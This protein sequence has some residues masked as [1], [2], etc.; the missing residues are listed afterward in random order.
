MRLRLLPLAAVAAAAIACAAA[1]SSGAAS[2]SLTLVH[3]GQITVATYGNG[4][5]TIVVN[6]NGTLGGTS[7]AWINAFAKANGLK[8]KLFQTTFTSAILAVQQGKADLTLDI[9]YNPARGKTMLYTYPFSVEGLEVFTNKSFDYTG[10][11]SLQGKKVAAVTGVVWDSALQKTFGSGLQLYPSQPEAATALLN[12]QVDAYFEADAQYFAPPISKSPNIV[13][14]N[15]SPGQFGVPGAD[16]K[17]LGYLVVN[18]K[19]S[20][21]VNGLDSTLASLEKSGQWSKTLTAA[22]APAGSLPDQTPSRVRPAMSC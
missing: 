10:P 6:S 5:P 20:S 17:S 9:Y 14:H 3:P 2:P 11:S 13:A 16:I 19:E 22:G 8:V 1:G 15:I 4:F 18:C 12:G 7:G 21:L